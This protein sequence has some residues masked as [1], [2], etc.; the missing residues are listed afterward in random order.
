MAQEP[1]DKG[2]P[3]KQ[4]DI[5]LEF[6]NTTVDQSQL[7]GTLSPTINKRPLNDS[8]DY[9]FKDVDAFIDAPFWT[10]GYYRPFFDVDT[11]QVLSRLIHSLLPLRANFFERISS[12][13]DLYGPF[14]ICTTLI[15]ILVVT[16]SFDNYINKTEKY[17]FT[18]V[19]LAAGAIYGYAL[20]VPAI[21]SAIF[22]WFDVPVRTLEVIS[23]YGY[24]FSIYI[25]VA[26]LSLFPSN[27][28]RWI[29]AGIGF[30]VSELFL[31]INFFGVIRQ[32]VARGLIILVCMGVAH[33][34]LALLLKLYFFETI[35]MRPNN[36]TLPLLMS[37]VLKP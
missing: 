33:A 22:Y 6:V 30:G 35:P 36:S 23:I 2:S 8:E 34:G 29:I 27:T 37:S 9:G 25:L 11:K 4:D 15:F 13:P 10:L 28:V 18:K 20:L 32:H 31:L 16:N 3:K 21:V 12:N 7:E 19:T 1:P 17:E 24:S 5:T 14:W 26:I